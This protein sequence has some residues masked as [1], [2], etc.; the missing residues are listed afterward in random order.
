MTSF[1]PADAA[2]TGLVGKLLPRQ[3]ADLK[4]CP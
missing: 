3:I 4:Q 2:P 1:A